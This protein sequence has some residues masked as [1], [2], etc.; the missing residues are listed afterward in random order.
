LI[1]SNKV[2]S[3]F[4]HH[5]LVLFISIFPFGLVWVGGRGGNKKGQMKKR[6][7]EDDV[8]KNNPKDLVSL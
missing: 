4:Y 8:E 2:L 1:E 5:F 6:K 7:R 3:T